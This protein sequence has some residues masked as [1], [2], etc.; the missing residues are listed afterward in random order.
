LNGV[1]TG[2]VILTCDAI[3]YWIGC[4]YKHAHQDPGG[5]V[6][7]YDAGVETLGHVLIN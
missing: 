4:E 6:L 3:G 2:I 5:T 1:C 7:A